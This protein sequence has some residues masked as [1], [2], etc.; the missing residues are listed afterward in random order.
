MLSAGLVSHTCTPP[1]PPPPGHSGGMFPSIKNAS[2]TSQRHTRPRVPV[3][4][5]NI[6][7][8]PLKFLKQVGSQKPPPSPSPLYNNLH[9]NNE[10]IFFFDTRIPNYSSYVLIPSC[11]WNIETGFVAE[12]S[13]STL[14]DVFEFVPTE[15]ETSNTSDICWFVSS[16]LWSVACSPTRL[17]NSFALVVQRF[18]AL[19]MASWCLLR[20]GGGGAQDEGRG[21]ESVW[22]TCVL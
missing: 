1:P 8:L 17:W 2:H 5:E 15:S 12:G 21:W 13:T 18:S 10:S 3:T 6:S 14:L 20:C 19:Y 7:L 16:K 4:T 11:L 9:L 22:C